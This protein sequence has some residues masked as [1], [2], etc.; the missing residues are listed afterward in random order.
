M[1]LSPAERRHVPLRRRRPAVD[2]Q[3]HATQPTCAGRQ[4]VDDGAWR[5]TAHY[6]AMPLDGTVIRNVNDGGFYRFAG[7]AP[8]L[9]RCDIG[10]GCTAPTMVDGQTMAKLG[11]HDAR[12]AAHAPVPGQRHD[13]GQRRRQHALP[14]RRQRA[15]AARRR[16]PPAA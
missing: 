15:A 9:V 4:Q 13:A 11:T 16:P 8:L 12:A 10:A 5:D 3:L 1:I 2:L 7:G 14:R 6:K